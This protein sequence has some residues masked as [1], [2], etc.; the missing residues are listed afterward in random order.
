M[1]LHLFQAF[2][3]ELEYMIVDSGSLDVRP[4]ADRVLSAA[5]P[6][7]GDADFPDEVEAERG[8]SWSNELTLHV[9]EL[10]TTEPTP[11]F[12]DL[13]ARMHESIGRING[14]LGPM[15]AMLMPAAMHPWMDPDREMRLWPHG[16]GEYYRT[17]DR[18]FD[19]RG[20]GWANLQS[21]HLNLP[22][23]GDDEFA[24]LHAAIRLVLPILPALC[25]SSPMMNGRFTGLLDNRLDVYQ[26]NARKVPS[27]SGRT[28][29]EPAYTRADY[30]R[31]I[32]RRIYDDLA[33]HDP[34]GLLRH[35]WANARGAIARFDRSA[36]EIRVMDVQECPAADVAICATVAGVLQAIIGERWTELY[37]QQAW[38]VESLHRV[39]AECVRDG[40]AA[41]IRDPAYLH[42]LG[43]LARDCTAADLWRHLLRST[44]T[45][46][47]EDAMVRAPVEHILSHGTLAR[48]IARAVVGRVPAP[49]EPVATDRARVGEVYRELC[50]CLADGRLFH[51]A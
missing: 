8:I 4:I 38:S 27:V 50:A 43:M 16:N 7:G 5:A 14:L 10:K 51:G 23:F 19:C 33:P 2:G 35:E 30:E 15:G 28:I 12:R 3:V 31:I 22:F 32:L 20:H 11:T 25:A 13:P 37:T 17:F 9:L 46:A 40:E 24:R 49:G 48:R 47:D 44:R 39:F 34:E 1:P 6:G 41:V 21:V 45:V 26:H 18:I 29:P 36:I 42:A